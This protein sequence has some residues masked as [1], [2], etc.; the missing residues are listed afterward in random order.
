MKD[1]LFLDANVVLD[2]VLAREPYL[3]DAEALFK[4]RDR[5]EV[6]FYRSALTLANLAYITQRAKKNATSFISILL[7]WVYVIDLGKDFFHLTLS[8]QLRDF[9]D[10]LQYFSALKIQGLDAIITR[11]KSDFR[12]SKIAVLTPSEYLKLHKP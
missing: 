8:S 1:R 2:F 5:E 10:G 6:D 9:E 7:K 3:K 11:N 4:L 12:P